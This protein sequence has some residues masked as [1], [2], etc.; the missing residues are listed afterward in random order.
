MNYLKERT[1]LARQRQANITQLLTMHITSDPAY[2]GGRPRIVG[3]R[4]TVKD[5][6]GFVSLGQEEEQKFIEDHPYVT[7]DDVDACLIYHDS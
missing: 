6:V 4:I 1:S 7:N 2:V 5:I 3:S